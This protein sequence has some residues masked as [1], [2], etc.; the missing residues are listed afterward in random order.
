MGSEREGFALV[1]HKSSLTDFRDRDQLEDRYLLGTT[2][3]PG[4]ERWPYA[5]HSEPFTLTMVGVVHLLGAK[6]SIAKF[7]WRSCR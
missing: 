2:R 6:P 3:P 7:I 5:P 1:E 4:S